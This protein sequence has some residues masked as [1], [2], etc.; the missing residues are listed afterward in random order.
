MD[1]GAWR[2]TAH[3]IAKSQTRLSTYAR[4]QDITESHI[5]RRGSLRLN[6]LRPVG[7]ERA[8]G[9]ALGGQ[10]HP[11]AAPSRGSEQ[12]GCPRP[13][14][15]VPS[16]KMGSHPVSWGTALEASW[17]PPLPAPCDPPALGVF[18]SVSSSTSACEI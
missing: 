10:V 9:Q 16:M 3:G 4:G 5:S 8:V 1:R 2:A 17:D 12:A 6:V 14:A 7:L 11:A 18:A 13:E 15:R